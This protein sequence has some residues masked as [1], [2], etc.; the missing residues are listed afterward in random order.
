MLAL[1]GLK[2]LNMTEN[3]TSILSVEEMLPAVAQ[4]TIGIACRTN[5]NT[6]YS[7]CRERATMPLD[8]MISM[9][10]VLGKK[11]GVKGK[12]L[13]G[14]DEESN[15]WSSYAEFQN[16]TYWNHDDM[17]SNDDPIIRCFHWFTI[18]DAVSTF[19]FSSVFTCDF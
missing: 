17:P 1:A 10:Y 16:I 7:R 9:G 14:S 8:D 15:D 2:R 13:K 6:M 19:S 4:G 3:V 12:E 5:D 18:A 11:D